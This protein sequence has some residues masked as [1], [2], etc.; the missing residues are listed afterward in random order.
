MQVVAQALLLVQLQVTAAVMVA[1]TGNMRLMGLPILG[2][3]LQAVQVVEVL[4]QVAQ[5]V[6]IMVLVE[7]VVKV[8]QV[9]RVEMDIVKAEAEA[10]LVL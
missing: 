10:V 2:F 1:R 5:V 4:V 3:H 9:E 8:T 7:L 6:T